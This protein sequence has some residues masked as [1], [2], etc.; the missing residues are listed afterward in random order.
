MIWEGE[1]E[2]EVKMRGGWSGK[3]CEHKNMRQCCSLEGTVTTKRSER[4]G[5]YVICDWVVS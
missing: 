3:N 5:N 4:K 2:D 1:D